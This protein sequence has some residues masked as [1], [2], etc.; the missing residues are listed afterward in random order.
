MA[1]GASVSR[2]YYLYAH[3]QTGQFPAGEELDIVNTD[4]SPC[5]RRYKRWWDR[6]PPLTTATN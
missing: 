5:V 3:C 2:A 4:F 1:V 6:A